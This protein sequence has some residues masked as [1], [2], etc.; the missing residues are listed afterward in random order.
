MSLLLA[1]AMQSIGTVM[2][3]KWVD[4]GGVVS[5]SFCS[6]QGPIASGLVM[7]SG[8]IAYIQVESSRP[9]T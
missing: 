2:N 6:A 7:N 4:Y 1:N 9:E 8:F 5:G 3:F